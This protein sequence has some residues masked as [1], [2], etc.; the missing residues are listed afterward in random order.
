VVG[1]SHV[2]RDQVLNQVIL[3]VVIVA[4]VGVLWWTATMITRPYRANRA[5]G[6]RRPVTGAVASREPRGR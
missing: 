3:A 4:A 5:G 6:A 1:W 2:P